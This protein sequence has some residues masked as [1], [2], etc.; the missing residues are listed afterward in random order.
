MFTLFFWI[1]E[2]IYNNVKRLY[3]WK[4]SQKFWYK[5]FLFTIKHQCLSHICWINLP[6]KVLIRSYKSLNNINKNISFQIWLK[7]L[8][9][10]RRINSKQIL[11]FLLW[12][13]LKTFIISFKLWWCSWNHQIVSLGFFNSHTL[14]KLFYFFHVYLFLLLLFG[15]LFFSLDCFFYWFLSDIL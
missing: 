10:S 6:Y 8:T 2:K 7:Y 9:N 5:I 4:I 3:F 14:I 15:S 13:T 11:Y 1:H 12:I